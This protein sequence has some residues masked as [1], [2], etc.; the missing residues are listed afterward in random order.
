MPPVVVAI[1]PSGEY[2]FVSTNANSVSVIKTATNEVVGS[3]IPVG[4]YSWGTAITPDG[5]R[6]CVANLLSNDVSMI[7][8]ATHTVVATVPVGNG[9]SGVGIGWPL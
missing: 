5:K 3:P 2:L 8:A 7:D 1:T 4:T 9:P 6:V